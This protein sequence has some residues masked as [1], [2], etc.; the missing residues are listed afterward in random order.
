[1]WYPDSEY[2]DQHISGEVL[3]DVD[4]SGSTFHRCTFDKVQ[5]PS[6]ALVGVTFERC[7]FVGC[8]MSNSDIGDSTFECVL[9]EDSKLL[10]VNLAEAKLRGVQ[11][12][13][14]LCRLMSF[15][16]ASVWDTSFIGCD[17]GE[18][19]FRE[20][21]V[22]SSAWVRC[23]LSSTSY[24]NAD[25]RQLDI[26]E[27]VL[28]GSLSLTQCRGFTVSS[29]QLIPLAAALVREV[30]ATL[31]DEETPGPAELPGGREV[32]QLKA[33]DPGVLQAGLRDA[34]AQLRGAEGAS[35]RPL[36]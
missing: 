9:V 16:R 18:S 15:F 31:N 12:V 4:L 2:E 5:M 32:S 17:F 13:D 14:S 1:M 20:A 22:R 6:T 35:G 26:R 28:N 34:R 23:D 8:D 10:G 33:V 29:A 36:Q 25:V 3:V 7:R 19:D 27:S 21:T 30:G 11:V 24:V